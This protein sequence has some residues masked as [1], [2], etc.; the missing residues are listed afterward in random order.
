MDAGGLMGRDPECHRRVPVRRPVTEED[1]IDAIMRS[2]RNKEE[3]FVREIAACY[4]NQIFLC[5][6]LHSGVG[7]IPSQFRYATH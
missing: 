3:D 5:S 1:A 7:E 2:A 6:L 4:F